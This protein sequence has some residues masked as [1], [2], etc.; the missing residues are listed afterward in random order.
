MPST[1]KEW[2]DDILNYT[3]VSSYDDI[4]KI[5]FG[6][7][8]SSVANFTYS[9]KAYSPKSIPAPKINIKCKSEGYYSIAVSVSTDY[10]MSNVRFKFNGVQISPTYQLP[11]TGDPANTSGKENTFYLHFLKGDIFSIEFLGGS[12]TVH[13]RY[14]KD[15]EYTW[16][17]NNIFLNYDSSSGK[18][19]NYYLNVIAW[20][21]ELITDNDGMVTATPTPRWSD[22]EVYN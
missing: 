18:Y 13:N 12:C 11:E 6:S 8:R 2:V 3:T 15:V 5:D 16:E 22:F 9:E 17:D 7:N 21:Y 10:Y 14:S 20:N 19:T 4:I 1:K